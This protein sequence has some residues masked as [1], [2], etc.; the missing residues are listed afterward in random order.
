M[1]ADTVILKI[2]DLQELVTQAFES[3]QAAA[4]CDEGYYPKDGVFP[5]ETASNWWQTEGQQLLEEMTQR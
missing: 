5:P 2:A 4:Y 1:R 3:G